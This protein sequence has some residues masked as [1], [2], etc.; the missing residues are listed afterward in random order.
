M[1]TIKEI[2]VMMMKIMKTIIRYILKKTK[3]F[4]LSFWY[5]V[6]PLDSKVVLGLLVGLAVTY[7]K[8]ATG[9]FADINSGPPGGKFLAF[10][11]LMLVTRAFKKLIYEKFPSFFNNKMSKNKDKDKEKY[12]W[13]GS[14][15]VSSALY[16]YNNILSEEEKKKVSVKNIT[17]LEKVSNEYQLLHGKIDRLS[18]E[19]KVA[20][21]AR[22]FF[23]NNKCLRDM[24][25]KYQI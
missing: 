1:G 24:D 12:I 14:T 7:S 2:I 21:K 5:Y 20:T 22:L 3:A 25:R 11:I 19:K 9:I 10:A 23:L 13:L 16:I 8:S 15:C 18:I 4:A 17:S 6:K